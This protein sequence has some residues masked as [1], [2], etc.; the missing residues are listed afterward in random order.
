MQTFTL[1]SF[2]LLVLS[3][4][5]FLVFSQDPMKLEVLC[6]KSYTALSLKRLC[7]GIAKCR[8][9][10]IQSSKK[11]S[12]WLKRNQYKVVENP[13][14]KGVRVEIINPL[15]SGLDLPWCFS[16]KSIRLPGPS[17]KKT[18]IE[19]RETLYYLES[20]D[21]HYLP[22]LSA[23]KHP[24]RSLKQLKS[25]IKSFKFYYLMPSSLKG[26]QRPK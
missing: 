5:S 22:R 10:N 14:L 9:K 16:K 17:V 11:A 21:T 3:L 6:P 1:K 15:L 26:C 24:C 25:D 20:S 18:L 4:S 19:S 7:Q 2:V 8:W 23:I 12:I 13:L